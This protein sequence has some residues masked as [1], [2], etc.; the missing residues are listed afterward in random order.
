[1]TTENWL[2]NGTNP[3][4]IVIFA[5][6][7]MSERSHFYSNSK[8]EFFFSN[9]KMEKFLPRQICIQYT[10][11][12]NPQL[13]LLTLKVVRKL[14]QWLRGATTSWRVRRATIDCFL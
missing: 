1:M 4:G 11:G 12:M 13:R 2:I 14:K 7:V 10:V 8:I 9:K 3:I 6:E 5:D